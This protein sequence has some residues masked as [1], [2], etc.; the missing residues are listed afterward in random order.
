M[1]TTMTVRVSGELSSFVAQNIGEEGLYESTSEYIRALI[2]QDKE[3]SEQQ[4]FERL[5]SEL[6]L[7]FSAPDEDFQTL[8][9]EDIFA[10]NAL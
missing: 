9:A 2:R 3:R 7:A 6:K 1:T 8:T 5:K 4:A 10:R